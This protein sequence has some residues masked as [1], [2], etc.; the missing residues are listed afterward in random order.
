MSND[1]LYTDGALVARLSPMHIGH[2][3]VIREMIRLCGRCVVFIGSTNAPWSPR[4]FFAYEDRKRFLKLVFPDLIVLPLPD[5][6][7]NTT[8]L[9]ELD[10]LL[11]AVGMNPGETV[12][13]GGVDEDV[14]V[15]SEEGKKRT[16]I[17]S[18]F[19]EGAIEISATKV[20]YLLAHNLPLTDLLN[21][22]V[23]D[24]VKAYWDRHWPSA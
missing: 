11:S 24:P 20:R 9:A 17:V 8:W 23:I 6:E 13:F 16:H 14:Y 4:N 5:F 2:E 19:G 7:R 18:R 10:N 3:R 21:P 1:I 22:L 12:F 15:L